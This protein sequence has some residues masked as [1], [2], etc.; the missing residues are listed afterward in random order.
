[1]VARNPLVRGE[2]APG[3]VIVI[4]PRPWQKNKSKE[5]RKGAEERESDKPRVQPRN[6]SG[7]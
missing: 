3:R 2:P 5:D 7:V 4:I 1:M 6:T